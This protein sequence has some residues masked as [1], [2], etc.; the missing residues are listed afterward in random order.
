MRA[1]VPLTLAVLLAGGL[2]LS[3]SSTTQAQTNLVA[4]A[5]ITREHIGQTVT[6]RARIVDVISDSDGVSFVLDDRT[7]KIQMNLATRLYNQKSDRAGLNYDADMR[8]TGT[9]VDVATV[10]QLDVTNGSDAVIL[11]PGTSD[12]VAV[13]N[14]N[15]P[16]TRYAGVGTLVAVEGQI[17]EIVPVTSGFTFF[18]ADSTGTVR[19]RLVNRLLRYAPPESQLV[20][21]APIRVVGRVDYTRRLGVQIIP[22]LGYDV[23]IRGR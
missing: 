13:V 10:L 12:N 6:V 18:M 21:G 3:A 4:I 8:V 1:I 2:L 20:V 22:A 14:A 23:K 17:T 15:L 9:V 11:T 16:G 5:S 19:V 7:D